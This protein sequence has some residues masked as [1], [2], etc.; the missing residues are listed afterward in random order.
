MCGTKNSTGC[1]GFR[2]TAAAFHGFLALAQ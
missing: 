1:V 2:E